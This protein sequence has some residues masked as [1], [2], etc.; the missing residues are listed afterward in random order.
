MVTHRDA[1]EKHYSLMVNIY[2]SR[3][4]NIARGQ[5][6][7]IYP[8]FSDRYKLIVDYYY[9]LLPN[10]KGKVR[11]AQEQINKC[12]RP[13]ERVIEEYLNGA[14]RRRLLL[15]GFRREAMEADI[16]RTRATRAATRSTI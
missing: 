6:H 13:Y 11:L 7:D 8:L 5:A 2:Y 1:E 4:L 16:D 15:D 14:I 12:A 10:A 9:R 3:L